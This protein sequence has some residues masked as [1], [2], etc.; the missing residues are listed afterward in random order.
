MNLPFPLDV[1]PY[2]LKVV[3]L[4]LAPTFGDLIAQP[5]LL[6]DPT[7]LSQVFFS[8]VWT[9]LGPNIDS[10]SRS[11]KHDLL[12]PHASGVVLE[13]GAGHGHTMQ[14]LD[15]TRVTRYVAIEPNAYMHDQIYKMAEKCGFSVKRGEVAVLGCGVEDVEKIKE[16]LGETGKADTVVSILTLC[17]IRDAKRAMGRLLGEALRPGGEM[18]WIEHVKNPL[19]K[20]RWAIH[21]R[22]NAINSDK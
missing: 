4:G 10:N 21:I 1:I 11:V 6:L 22:D 14:Y 13:I 12:H 9:V 7:R 15:R 20:E 16:A 17:S 8:H 2:Y 18:L 5:S 3:Q 19:A